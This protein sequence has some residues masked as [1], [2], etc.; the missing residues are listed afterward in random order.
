MKTTIMKDLQL[1]SINEESFLPKL[2]SHFGDH[3]IQ[4]TP[5]KYCVYDYIGSDGTTYELK[6]RRN[7][8]TRYDTTLMPCHKV[9]HNTKQYFLIRFSDQDCYIE[10]DKDK[11]NTYETTM[12]TDCRPGMNFKQKEHYLI[13]ITD[14][15]N[16]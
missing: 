15:T 14:L 13:P 4:K 8:K 3:T 5:N 2:V 11:F 6:T 7:T 10:Y 1:G 16:F 9:L 12:V